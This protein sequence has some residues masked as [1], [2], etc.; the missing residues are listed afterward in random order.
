[1]V[2]NVLIPIDGSDNSERAFHFYLDEIRKPDDHLLLVHV[3]PSPHLPSFSLQHPMSVPEEEWRKKIGEI[4]QE[5][6]KIINHYEVM[7]EQKKINKEPLINSGKPGEVILEYAKTKNAD[8]IV[9]GNRGL[10]A[11]RR[12]FVGSVSD[13]VLHHSHVPVMIVPPPS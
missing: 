11:V 6:Q 7:C 10:N 9:M 5:S 2:R 3:Q 1:M 4:V 8:M 13:Y 12:T